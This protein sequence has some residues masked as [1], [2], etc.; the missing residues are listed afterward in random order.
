MLVARFKAA[1][2]QDRVVGDPMAAAYL[3]VHLW[4]RAVDSASS[5]DPDRVSEAVRGQSISGPGGMTHV[6]E[7]NQ[8]TWKTV[9]LGQI[10]PDG[11]IV[12]LWSSE[13]PIQPEPY[14]PSRSPEDWNRFLSDLQRRWDGGWENPGTTAR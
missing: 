7:R 14:P 1:Y 5:V 8:H 11:Q 9:R 4:A 3:G 12:E 2:G 13:I 10:G 6:D